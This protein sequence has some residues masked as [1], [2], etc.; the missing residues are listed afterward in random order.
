MV[1]LRRIIVVTGL[2][3]VA[4]QRLVTPG[5]THTWTLLVAIALAGVSNEAGRA[6][7]LRV[8]PRHL[9]VLVNLQ[10][11]LDTLTL[12]LLLHLGG[13]VTD[14][15]VVIFAPAFFAYGA[16]LPLHHSLTHV[17]VTG[18]EL[19]IV[20]LAEQEGLAAAGLDTHSHVLVVTIGYLSVVNLLCTCLSHYLSALLRKQEEYSRTLAA[21]RGALLERN[22]REAERVRVLLAVAQHVS[23][24]QTVHDLLRAVCETTA[25]LVRAPR[26]EIFLWESER[27]GL[28]L[29]A[30]EGVPTAVFS[31]EE[32]RSPAAQALV[33]RLRAGEV[34]EFGAAPRADALFGRGV[35]APMV[36]RGSFQGTLFVGCD[37]DSTDA[38]KDL[39]QG[40][41]RQAALALDSVRTME[42]QQEDAE[43]SRM[44]LDISQG[45]NSCLD[46]K[47]LWAMLARGASTVLDLPWCVASRFDERGAAFRVEGAHGVPEAVLER[48]RTTVVH[49]V[50][51]P[52]M[53][54][55]LSSR[56]LVVSE[57]GECLP[58]GA[59]EGWPTQAWVAIPLFHGD[60]VAGLLVVGQREPYRSF[61]RRQRRLAEGL[62]HHASIALENAHQVANLEAADRLKSEFVST[63][64]HELRT[65]LNVIIGY[66]EMLR[67]EA[68]GP[69]TLE[70]RD[71]IDR[72]D[73]RGRELLELIEATLHVGR[74]EAGREL[75]D[76]AP[77]ELSE[78]V[79][80]LKASTAGLPRPP[81]VAFEWDMPSDVR[82]SIM[83]DR[84][85]LALVVRN[86]VSNAFKF[87]TEG[88]VLVC[89]TAS[90]KT[91]AI[92][93][94]DTGVGIGAE[95]LPIIFEMFR[96]VDGSTTRRHGGVGLGL[97][98]VKQFV[99]RLGGT[100]DVQ[101]IPG[102]GSTF[103]VVLPDVG[104]DD[105]RS[106][107]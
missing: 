46:E 71:L 6:L 66:V 19:L 12:V 14:L 22:A 94:R 29:A 20:G 9:A 55:A 41:A 37:G 86:L 39:V 38:I 3:A 13:G 16:V 68:A 36:Y 77:I 107:A 97:Y 65:P 78:L 76:I 96:Q 92:E 33:D 89:I 59:C 73:A 5:A 72:L 82:D 93:V 102:E 70:Q 58:F 54:A 42:Q 21:E 64:S 49:P 2:G 53:Q 30:T 67:E 75:V 81:G 48:L 95:H 28:V 47:E 104:Y 1:S 25:A 34:V 84:A 10:V 32:L 62:G 31:E 99:T 56:A 24:T 4:V 8:A 101:S 26:V 7:V 40:V 90:E 15:P 87:T 88:R 23:G 52:S 74:L 11:V 79:Q 17:V 50:D 91:L 69:I 103:R 60:W 63:M 105:R 57:Q 61:S 45:L 83:T 85:K 51:H 44:L 98:I 18:F 27:D 43:V 100:V 35:A 106:A 80:A